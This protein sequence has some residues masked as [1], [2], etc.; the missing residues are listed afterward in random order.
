MDDRRVRGIRSFATLGGRADPSS[1]R[2]LNHL[3]RWRNGTIYP[4]PIPWGTFNVTQN[5]MLSY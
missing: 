4:A 5:I 1:G 3:S 2:D